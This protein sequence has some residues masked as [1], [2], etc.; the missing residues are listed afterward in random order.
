MK[1]LKQQLSKESVAGVLFT[2]PFTIGFLLFM[3]VP[4]GI[5]LYYSFCDYDI[6]SPPVF[7]GL[8]NFISM[9][10]DETFFKTL[11]VTFFF[12]FVSVPL[13]LLFALIVAMLLLENSKMSGFYRAAYYLPSIIG[14]SV[15]VSILWKRMFAMD[16][17]VNK[18]LGMAGIQ[19]SFSWLGDTRTAIWVLI[20]LVVWQ[21]GSSMLIFLSSLKQVPQSLYEAAEVDGASAPAKFFKITLPLL[22]PTIFFNLV[23]QMINGFLAFTQC[24]IITQGK[25]MNSTLLYTVYMYKQSFEFYNTG[26]GAALAWVMLAVIGLITLFLFATKR[27]WVYEGGL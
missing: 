20:L 1:A 9:F 23:M 22:T 26:Y 24:Y 13:K 3:L 14:G 16:G 8:K 12:A 11:K 17:V 10:Q 19:T 27:F 25:P 18:L 5:S 6:L 15:A 21:F 2:L 4:M 7:T